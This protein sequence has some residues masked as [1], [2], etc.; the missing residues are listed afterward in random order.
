MMKTKRRVRTRLCSLMLAACMLVS[1]LPLS[2]IVALAAAEEPV[3]IV[4]QPQEQTKDGERQVALTASLEPENGIAAS[5]I[6]I[7]LEE[8]EAVALQ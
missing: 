7:H 2:A 4:W 8:A 3:S 5:M 6:E 1:L